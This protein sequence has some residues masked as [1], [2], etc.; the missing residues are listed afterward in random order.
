[1]IYSFIFLTASVHLPRIGHAM[2]GFNWYGTERLIRKYLATKGIP[3]YVYPFVIVLV[4]FPSSE[5]KMSRIFWY[6]Y[7]IQG[8]A[9]F[10]QAFHS[11]LF[12]E[13]K[14]EK[15]F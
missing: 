3:T 4:C 15:H 6:H 5:G 13:T 7:L 1:M 9:F 11:A 10:C 14:T 2:K 8:Q 12:S